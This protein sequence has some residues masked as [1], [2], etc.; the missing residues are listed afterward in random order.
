MERVIGSPNVQLMACTNPIKDLW[1]IRFDVTTRDDGSVD[2]ME[3]EFDHKPSLQ[4]VKAIITNFYNEQ[5]DHC[6]L[7]GLRYDGQLVWLSS[8]NQANY[9]AAYDLAVQTQGETLPY[10]IKLGTE[11]SPTYKEFLTLQDFKA[12]YLTVQ[13]HI[14]KTINDGWTKKDSIDW[15]QYQA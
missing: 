3:H 10:K 12:F 1:R 11:D 9:K 4:E 14:D 15:S 2:Y 6:I 7:S 8:E 13:K 5:T